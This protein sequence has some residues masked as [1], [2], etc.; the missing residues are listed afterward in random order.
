MFDRIV[1]A[2]DADSTRAQHVIDAAVELASRHGS[3]VLVIHVREVERPGAALARPGAIP[4]ALTPESEEEAARI[5]EQA[6]Q[7]LR[8]AGLRAEGRVGQG[9]GSTA[10]ELL[11][12]ALEFKAGLILVGDRGSHLTDLLLGGVAHRIVH[13][14]Q[15]SVLVVR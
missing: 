11:D 12:S 1:A 5:V 14:A 4:P 15:C 10:H 3:Q 2:I 6:L 9:L 8:A 7:R 13:Q